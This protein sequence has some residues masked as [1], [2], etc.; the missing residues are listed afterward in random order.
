M[1]V[2]IDTN[3]LINAS[4]DDYNYGNRLI[5]AVLEGK[6]RAFANRQT[7]KEN[8]LIANR[9]VDDEEFHKKLEQYFD[10][11]NP[12]EGKYIQVVEDE[13]DNKILASAIEAGVD[14]LV[15]S[16]WHLLKL[17]EYEG[18]KIITPQGFWAEFESESGAGWQDWL[19][20]FIN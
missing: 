9:K 19:N 6:I 14:Y 12:V 4:E 18:V 17:G 20:K 8:R 15:T 5:N 7:L 3:I 13:E 11:V 10:L 16:D 2:V 1:K